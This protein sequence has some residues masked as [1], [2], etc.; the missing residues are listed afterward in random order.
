MWL[1]VRLDIL[2]KRLVNAIKRAI[3]RY[4]NMKDTVIYPQESYAIVAAVFEVHKQ[5]GCGFLEKVYQ[6]ALAIEFSFR[7]IPYEREKHLQLLYKG[8]AIGADY[9][10]DFVCYDKIIVELKAVDELL[11]IHYAQVS[12]YLHITNYKLGILVNFN[13][14]FVA[15]QRIV[16]TGGN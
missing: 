4:N 12:N 6:E 11:D 13:E 14:E 16:N 7:G 10:A 3:L 5:L 15:P 9:V 2:S 1:G 8:R